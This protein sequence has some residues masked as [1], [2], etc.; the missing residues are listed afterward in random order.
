MLD[1]NY[2]WGEVSDFRLL[3]VGDGFDP[4]YQLSQIHKVWPGRISVGSTQKHKHHEDGVT[5]LSI[6]KIGLTGGAMASVL[7]A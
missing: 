4:Q 1:S 6:R 3:Q 7:G 2:W 5:N